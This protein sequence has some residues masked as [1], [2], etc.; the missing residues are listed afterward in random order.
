MGDPTSMTSMKDL[1]MID[2][3]LPGSPDMPFAKERVNRSR[4]CA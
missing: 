3:E 1:K 4:G 2:G